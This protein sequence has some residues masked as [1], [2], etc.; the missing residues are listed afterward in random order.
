MTLFNTTSATARDGR[1]TWL[2]AISEVLSTVAP[3]Y[4]PTWAD[5]VDMM[6]T[7]P[8]QP[9]RSANSVASWPLT[10]SSSSPSSSTPTS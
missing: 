8:D 7:D 5:V 4:G 10:V 9:R 3:A 2:T 6:R 1:P